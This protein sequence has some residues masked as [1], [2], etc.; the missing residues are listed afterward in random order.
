M[1]KI[2]WRHN[3]KTREGVVISASVVREQSQPDKRG[4]FTVKNVTYLV[5]KED[6][7][8]IVTINADD[9]NPG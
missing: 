3:D 1:L 5:I 8:K 6:D 2:R 7:G 9:V 4:A